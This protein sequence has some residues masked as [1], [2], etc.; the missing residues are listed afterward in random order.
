MFTSLNSAFLAMPFFYL[1]I[2]IQ[3]YIEKIGKYDNVIAR[4]AI[5]VILLFL[6]YILARL[7][8][9][10]DVD[11]C[12]WGNSFA[13]FYLIALLGSAGMILICSVF[14]VEAYVVR[15]ISKGTIFILGFNLWFI[16]LCKLLV[17][18]IPNYSHSNFWGC[19]WG[20]LIL[21]VSFFL[22]LILQR[23]F[24]I[25]LGNRK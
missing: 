8:G 21:L 14:N 15:T 23:Y 18:W 5:G 12:R 19:I 1:G 24:P 6:T 3:P 9:R 17:K 7:N 10:V 16:E 13:L 2:E 11:M 25:L 20:A 4:L 22:I